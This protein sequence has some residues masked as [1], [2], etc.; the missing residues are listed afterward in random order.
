MYIL[1]EFKVEGLWGERNAE[2]IFNEDINFLIGENSSGKTTIIY[3]ISSILSLDEN[4]IKEF[5]FAKC[6][7][8]L[9][10]KLQSEKVI[11]LRCINSKT[12]RIIYIDENGK[13][14]VLGS[15]EENLFIKKMLRWKLEENL[16]N[17]EEY[18]SLDELKKKMNSLINLTWLSIH[19][20]T[21][22]Y[23][24]RDTF[25]QPIDQRL[26]SIKSGLMKYFSSLSQKY[27]EEVSKFQKNIFLEF[28][29]PTIDI[30]LS[31]IIKGIDVIETEKDLKNIFDMLAISNS[32]EKI[33][34]L[35]SKYL[36]SIAMLDGEGENGFGVEN[37]VDIYNL[38][39]VSAIIKNYNNLK[40]KKDVIYHQQKLF[41]ETLNLFF[42][43]T[44][45]ALIS[46]QNELIFITKKN[47][48]LNDS[49]YKS[50]VFTVN[51]LSSGEKQIIILLA[52]TLLQDRK[53]SIF[54][55]DEPELSLHLQ[56]QELLTTSI[57][58]LNPN[59][60]IMFATHSPDIISLFDKK[61]IKMQDVLK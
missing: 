57:R 12:F 59:G 4:R 27:E 31:G 24:H 19:R 30:D 20:N 41:L 2:I 1:K 10:N 61:I 42:N 44:K 11:E 18:I 16:E 21:E 55:A 58:K 13:N 34:K 22:N 17:K 7:L 15:A 5:D 35:L 6:S 46:P 26:A 47:K 48:S 3:L 33:Q 36:D 29:D 38:A 49:K 54:I 9:Q 39:R 50:R 53:T 52:E 56:W 32:E 60:Q 45:S 51:E 37:Y 43:T 25:Y 14:K 8:K 23:N 40:K 28:I